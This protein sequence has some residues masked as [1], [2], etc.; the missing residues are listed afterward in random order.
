MTAGR[1][2]GAVAAPEPGA[3]NGVSAAL[4]D[5]AREIGGRARLAARRLARLPGDVKR[6]GLEA[7]AASL[8]SSERAILEA[9]A[10]DLAAADAAGIRGSLRD[11]L[12]L[13]RPRLAALAAA[14][15]EVAAQPDPVGEVSELT[16]RPNGM[17]VGR[18]RVPL[19][20]I[21]MIYEA[22]PNVTIDAA[23]LCLLAGNAVILRG[24]RESLHSNIALAGVLRSALTGAGIPAEAVQ[25]VDNPDRDLV[26]ALL[27]QSDTI[28]LAIPRGG[29]GLI[30]SVV[31]NARVPVLQHYKGVCHIYVD[32]GADVD[33]AVAIVANAKV[34]RPGTCNAVETLLV[35]RAAA[36]AMLPAAAGRLRAAGVELRGCDRTRALLGEGVVPATDEDWAAE[37]LDLVLAV[38]IVDSM[39]DAIDH[40]ATYGSNHTEAIVTADY[41]RARAFM[42]AV[43]AST[44]LINASTRLADGGQLGLGAE[45]GIS[46][47]K[48][49]AYGPMGA[50]ELTTTRFVV[51]GSGQVRT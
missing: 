38:R 48:I 7:V 50:R 19:G 17:Q 37:Y 21:L 47:S 23:A 35:H 2:G 45:I 30:R 22:R 1:H 24:G 8:E 5:V 40:I 15:R 6:A 31:Q 33:M 13:D 12:L 44:V 29:E 32:D 18:M 14:V 10:R 11:R 49:H 16:V 9:N 46:T 27:R 26:L 3:A 4:D 34:Q 20:V 25:Y 51:F 28:D 41:A 36:A 39:A 42:Q 43:D